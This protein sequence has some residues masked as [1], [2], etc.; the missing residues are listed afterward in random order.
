MNKA[1]TNLNLSKNSLDN[2]PKELFKSCTKL[3][4]LNIKDNQI[5]NVST[6]LI[7]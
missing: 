5:S 3:I 6:Y 1:L 7:K 2:L 4:E